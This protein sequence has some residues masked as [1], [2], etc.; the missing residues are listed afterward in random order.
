VRSASSFGNIFFRMELRTLSESASDPSMRLGIPVLATGLSR[1]GR[2]FSQRSVDN[3]WVSRF[4]CGLTC[5]WPALPSESPKKQTAKVFLNQAS[6][7][8][9]HFR[10]GADA[11]SGYSDA[12]VTPWSKDVSCGRIVFCSGRN[13]IACN[14]IRLRCG[15][16]SGGKSPD[17]LQ[18][19]VPFCFQADRWD[20]KI[21]RTP[22]Q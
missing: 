5:R 13:R 11:F 20:H 10:A 2:R 12:R 19:R 8:F 4:D 9:G 21:K 6:M 7:I 3:L 14:K 1:A 16:G 15:Y 17:L 18:H 22:L